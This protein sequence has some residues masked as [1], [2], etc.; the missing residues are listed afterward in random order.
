MN[1]YVEPWRPVTVDWGAHVE[2]E[3][4]RELH[5]THIL[6][7]HA[8]KVIASRCDRDDVLCQVDSDRY[9]VVHVTWSGRQE[10]PPHWPSTELFSSYEDWRE[11]GMMRD[12]REYT[13]T[14]A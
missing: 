9:A 14:D 4:A 8:L 10:P 7:G 11:R 3:L 2:A 13:G 1:S 5:P 6:A 12:H